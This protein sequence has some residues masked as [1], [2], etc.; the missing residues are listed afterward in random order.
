MS[1]AAVGMDGVLATYSNVGTK[2]SVAAPGGD[3]RLDDNG[4]GGI[5]GPGWNFVAGGPNLIFGYGTSAAAP[6][7]SGIAALL[8]AQTPGLS[9]AQLRARIETF[10]T[11]PPNALRSDSYG[12]GIVNAYNALTQQHGDP[13]A[14][15]LRLVN[16]T[17]GAVAATTKADAAGNFAFAKLDD[18]AYLLQAGEDEA[19]DAAIGVPGR[20]FTWAGGFAT[21]RVFNVVGHDGLTSA[22]SL[23]QPLESEPNDDL[24]HANLL[25]V[26]SYV[27]G[28]ITPPDARDIYAVTI[29]TAGIYTIETSGV[30]GTCGW[31]SSW[32]PTSRSPPPPAISSA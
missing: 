11:R 29:P 32:T 24:A 17:T 8:L 4:G 16:A 13:R 15:S 18:G 26:D 2:I 5:L 19:G 12:W 14:V 21:P 28:N 6:F 22:I 31:A 30:L 25:S 10:A 27:I 7:V 9:A 23:G 20:R 3:F 1:V